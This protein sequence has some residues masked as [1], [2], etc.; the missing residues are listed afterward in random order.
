MEAQSSLE[1]PHAFVAT[2]QDINKIWDVIESNEMVPEATVSCSDGIV[3][4]FVDRDKLINYNN[5]KRAKIKSIEITGRRREPYTT[6]VITLGR[7]YSY[8]ASVSIRGEESFVESSRILF[9]DILDGMKPWYSGF[10]RI[11]LSNVFL[12]IILSIF[13]ILQIMKSESHPSHAT[14]LDKAILI[15]A[16]TM[17]TMGIIVLSFFTISLFHQKLFPM[18]TFAIGQGISRHQYLE[19]IRWVVVIGFFISL[20]ASILTTLLF[21]L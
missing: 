5:P 12:S 19:N 9:T 16:I 17:F 7:K 6:I 20:L 10:A 4:N 14:P 21:T 2:S 11:D 15:L 1:F 13:L 3:R 8:N 18:S